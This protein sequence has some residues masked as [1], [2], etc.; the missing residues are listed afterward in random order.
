[1]P[2]VPESA[3]L[4]HKRDIMLKPIK[5]VKIPQ[6]SSNRSLVFEFSTQGDIPETDKILNFNG[7]NYHL[8]SLQASE[9][10]VYKI[11]S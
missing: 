11:N 2:N 3:V 5:S 7:L 9:C 1:M 4:Y 10:R 8:D 6:L